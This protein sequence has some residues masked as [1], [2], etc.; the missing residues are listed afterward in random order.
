MSGE[1]KGILGGV[2]DTLGKTVGGVTDTAGGAGKSCLEQLKILIL[3]VLA[4]SGLGNTVGD[5]TKGLTD[6]GM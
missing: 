6:T 2:T 1:N 5:T 4:V 3:I